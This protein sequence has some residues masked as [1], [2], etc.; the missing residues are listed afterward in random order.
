MFVSSSLE[1]REVFDADQ[2]LYSIFMFDIDTEDTNAGYFQLEESTHEIIPAN[3]VIIGKCVADRLYIEQGSAID[4]PNWDGTFP[5]SWGWDTMVNAEFN[6]SLAGGSIE[7]SAETVSDLRL[8]RRKSG[9][10]KWKTLYTR[11]VETVDDFQFAYYDRLAAGA[12]TYEYALVPVI[13]GE[14]GAI[15]STS[16]YSEFRDYYLFDK[17]QAYHIIMD[18]TN[19][20][21][22]NIEGAAQTTIARKYPYIIKN[23]YVGYYSG[24]LE[25][26]IVDLIDCE[27]D[28]EHAAAFRREFDQFLSNDNT[29]ILKDWL[30]NIYMVTVYEPVSQNSSDYLWLPTHNIN[31]TECGDAEG[32]GDLYDAGFINTDLDRE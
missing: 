25:A 29:K 3:E 13:N 19:S 12:T 10:I 9:D 2:I 32:I 27:W 8:K 5:S 21:T 20:I 7:F 28:V 24:T 17:D 31:W 6:G 1:D 23:G 18:A 22:Y 16:V 4:V 15:A 30:G 11:P 14:E 26:C